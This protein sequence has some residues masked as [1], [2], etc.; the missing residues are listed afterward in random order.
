MKK[1]ITMPFPVMLAS[2]GLG[3]TYAIY[4]AFALVSTVFIAKFTYETKGLE[5]EDMKG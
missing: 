5:L 1:A 4:A 3:G 2:I